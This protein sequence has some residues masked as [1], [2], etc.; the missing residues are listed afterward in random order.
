[1]INRF[2]LFLKNKDIEH[3]AEIKKMKTH[4]QHLYLKPIFRAYHGIVSS[5]ALEKVHQ[6][7]QLFNL[8]M[9]T[10]LKPCTNQFKLLMGLSCAHIIQECLQNKESLQPDHFNIQWLLE[11]GELLPIDYRYLVQEPEKIRPRDRPSL[12]Q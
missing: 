7:M 5:F 3:R 11:R 1:M 9:D 6:Y 8:D 12:R 10:I 4:R 2:L